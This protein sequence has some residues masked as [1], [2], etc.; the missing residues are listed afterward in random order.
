MTN[1]D[2][3]DTTDTEKVVISSGSVRYLTGAWRSTFVFIILSYEEFTSGLFKYLD[4]EAREHVTN[5]GV[6]NREQKHESYF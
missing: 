6:N 4:T 2:K 3:N 1:I 5:V